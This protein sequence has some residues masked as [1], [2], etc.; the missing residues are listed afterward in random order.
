[1]D[2]Q[3]YLA[4]VKRGVD[5]FLATTKRSTS[6]EDKT[7]KNTKPT[8]NPARRPY[9]SLDGFCPIELHS[10]RKW[11]KG[12]AEFEAVHKGLS[13]RF[14]S[15][16][17]YKLFQSNPTKYAPQML[18]CD[19]VVLSTSHKALAGKTDYGAFFDG[20]LFL[21]KSQES[22]TQFKKNP[23]RYVRIQHA[24]LD[25]NRIERTRTAMR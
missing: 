19:P 6:T 13:Y 8:I 2:K 18:G 14:Y 12:K 16:D 7:P 20:K 21:F 23:L 11:L 5:E 22:R 3:N 25:A 9:L 1:M 4:V 15:E 10:K 24:T 17:N